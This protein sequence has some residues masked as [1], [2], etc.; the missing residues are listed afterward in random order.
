MPTQYPG[1]TKQPVPGHPKK[2]TKVVAAQ[3]TTG[4]D[5]ECRGSIC[6]SHPYLIVKLPRWT[7]PCSA[8]VSKLPG[9]RLGV[10]RRPPSG[11]GV[12]PRLSQALC[13]PNQQLFCCSE[14]TFFPPSLHLW[15]SAFFTYQG[16]KPSQDPQVACMSSFSRCN[17]AA[18]DTAVTLLSF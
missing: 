15:I 2:R 3:R 12:M 13:S 16:G 8:D 6:I 17:L 14:S 10:A 9:M 5:G 1:S 7:Q 4:Q 18:W 11:L